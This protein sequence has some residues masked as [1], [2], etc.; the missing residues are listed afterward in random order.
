MENV[1]ALLEE[2]VNKNGSDLHITVGSPPRLRIDGR[3]VNLGETPLKPADAKELVYGLLTTDQVAEFEKRKEL[4]FSF[5]LA[6]VGRFRT[7][8]FYQRG[9]VGGVLRSIPTNIKNF[10][11]LGL[12][13]KTCTALCSLPKGLILLTGATGCGKSTTLASMIDF[14]NS[15]RASHIVTVE[16][17]IEFLH[18]NKLSHINQR[19][20]GQDTESFTRALRSALRQDP[21][22][23]LIGEMRDLET[24]EAALVISETGHLTFGTLH[25]SD[26]VQTI[27]RIVDVF[28]AHQQQQIRTQLSFTLQAAISQ[29]LI[30]ADDGGRALAAE[31]LIANS[32]VKALIRDGK[33]HQI[34][35]VIQTNQRMGMTTMNQSLARLVRD[36]RISLESALARST[37]SE[38]LAKLLQMETS[39]A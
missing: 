29:E 21:D 15:T 8:V 36:G 11:E 5:G 1:K 16:D 6:G 27:N 38:E 37:A 28:P 25:T 20:V 18:K 14:I 26:A 32:A 9:S 10:S 30:K 3:L 19:E 31:I 7:N 24:I 23:V 12:P 4:D 35:S 17:P 39:M 22:V 33:T 13:E 34:Y 2:L